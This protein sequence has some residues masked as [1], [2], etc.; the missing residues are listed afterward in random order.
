MAPNHPPRLLA[1][2]VNSE[3]GTRTGKKGGDSSPSVWN[4]R[5][6][7]WFPAVDRWWV[8]SKSVSALEGRGLCA[9]KYKVRAPRRGSRAGPYQCVLCRRRSF[10]R[11]PAKVVMA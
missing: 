6:T 5:A 11:P 3:V 8:V 7:T 10:R 1:V 2:H 4:T 9:L